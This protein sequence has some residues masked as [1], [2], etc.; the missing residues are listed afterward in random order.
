MAAYKQNQDFNIQKCPN[1][2]LKAKRDYASMRKNTKKKTNLGNM[3]ELEK[4]RL[5][6]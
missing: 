3:N 2:R 5:N 1:I 6:L 4:L